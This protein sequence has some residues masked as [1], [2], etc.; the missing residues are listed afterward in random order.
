VDSL[1]AQCLVIQLAEGEI[2]PPDVWRHDR[3]GALSCA[4]EGGEWSFTW[5]ADDV[6]EMASTWRESNARHMPEQARLFLDA[7][8]RL[9][10]LASEAGL[11][12]A[13]VIIHHF[14]R[15]ELRAVWE[16]GTVV[17][18][19]A[20]GGTLPPEPRLIGTSPIPPA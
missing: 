3:S 5:P 4:Y 6:A 19:E 11:G 8:Q 15:R 13:D 17:V 14:G 9:E 2:H 18:V 16:N 10:A 1:D 7:H 12:P 20:I